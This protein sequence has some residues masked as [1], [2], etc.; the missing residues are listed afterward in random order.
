MAKGTLALTSE[1]PLRIGAV[2]KVTG[3]FMSSSKNVF[4]RGKTFDM[5]NGTALL[6]SFDVEP[7]DEDLRSALGSEQQRRDD[8]GV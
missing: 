6:L 8:G 1:S 5:V 2:P 3:K 7:D 4:R